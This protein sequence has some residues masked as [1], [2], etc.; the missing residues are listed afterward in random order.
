MRLALFLA[1]K[2][3]EK[4]SPNPKVG[5]V[6]VKDGMIVGRG[7]HQ[8]FGGPHAEINAL[9]EAGLRAKGSTLYVTLEPCDH[10]GKT[11]PCTDSIIRAGVKRVVV[12]ASDPDS[13]ARGRGLRKL[14][15]KSIEVSLGLLKKEATELNADYIRSRITQ[16]PCVVVK[17]AMSADGKIATRT[18]DSKWI[19]S[20]Q[21]R[22][23]VHRLRSTVD[24]IIIGSE[25]AVRDNPHL[26]SHGEGRNPVRIVLDP[27]LRIPI[28]S[29][30]F[31]DRAPSIVFFASGQKGKT[32]RLL[33]QKKVMTVNL[34]Q[35]QGRFGLRDVIAKLRQYS[36]N[37]I[38]IEGGGETIASAFE[39]RVVTDLY[40]FVAPCIVG[41][42]NARTPVEGPGVTNVRSAV[43]LRGARMK[44]IG[45]DFLL[46]AK[47]LAR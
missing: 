12:A 43:K 2:G 35:R 34:R 41:G 11:P 18:G 17:A 39:D 15:T 16:K 42:R 21:S 19:S 14:R 24:A 29:R 32:L 1:K 30:V 33:R 37:R 44:K 9:S 22:A 13:K 28:G 45:S 27:H 8:Y 3:G 20:R 4:V 7:Y 23:Y 38:M 47:V 5:C 10:S 36:L 26:T 31:D 6:V 40:L 25:T 46:I